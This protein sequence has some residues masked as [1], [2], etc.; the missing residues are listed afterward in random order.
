MLGI[1]STT[2]TF[3][4]DPRD[5][6]IEEMERMV[7]SYQDKLDTVTNNYEEKVNI[8]EGRLVDKDIMSNSGSPVKNGHGKLHNQH[9]LYHS[10]GEREIN[11][12]MKA[13]TMRARQTG[14]GMSCL[15]LCRKRTW[16]E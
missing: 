13:R 15:S 7:A 14:L 3:Q 11:M 4:L 10:Q 16:L 2:R 5:E 1:C 8:L 12:N 6:K 9:G